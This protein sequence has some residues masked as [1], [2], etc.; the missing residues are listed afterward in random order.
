MIRFQSC[1]VLALISVSLPSLAQGPRQTMRPVVRGRQYA[2]AAMKLEPAQVGER[3]LRAGGNAFDAAVA[4]QAVLGIT[5]AAM[6]GIGSDAEIL[7]YDA[8]AGKVV[9][10]NAEGTAPK[11]ATIE[12]YRSHQGG[13]IPVD[14]SLL[15]GTVPGALDAWY[16][17]LDRW[18][19][20]TFAQVLAPAIE[21]VEQ[22]FPLNDRLAGEHRGYEE[23][24]QVRFEREGLLTGRRDAEARRHL[25]EP[26][27]GAYSPASGGRR[28]AG[29]RPGPERWAQGRTR[30]FL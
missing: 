22:G 27:T 25:P 29:L 6:N 12:W 14:D 10:L 9:S 28:A 8:K 7:I 20:M 3:V 1:L 4:M 26:R 13:K 15:S 16:L 17:M 11:L 24:A 21:M 18:G 23:T 2:V 30:P 5:D 19:T